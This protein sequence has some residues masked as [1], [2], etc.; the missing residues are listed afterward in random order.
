MLKS[1]IFFQTKRCRVYLSNSTHTHK[2]TNTTTTLTHIHTYMP[3]PASRKGVTYTNTTPEALL[4]IRAP[5]FVRTRHQ[6][7]DWFN[8]VFLGV[9]GV[10][11]TKKPK[12]HLDKF[13]GVAFG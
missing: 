1:Y 3:P 5:A 6:L 13:A 10:A 7:F 11:C 8:R 4:S 12:L 9:D 2:P